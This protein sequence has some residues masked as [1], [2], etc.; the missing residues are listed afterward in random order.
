MTRLLV[1]TRPS[2]LMIMPV[3]ALASLLYCWSVVMTARPGST[4]FT[5][6]C[7]LPP[8]AVPPGAEAGG[9]GTAAAPG[10]DAPLLAAGWFTSRVTPTAAAAART[11]TA[12]WVST[13]TP[14]RRP[15][16]PPRV[17]EPAPDPV[18]PGPAP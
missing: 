14:G 9:E 17:P 7:S 6:C 5:T 15:V 11:A 2:G 18:G 16:R 4:L 3:P 8:A 1:S 13:L 10:S 12:R